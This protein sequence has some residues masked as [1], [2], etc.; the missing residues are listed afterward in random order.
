MASKIQE[1]DDELNPIIDSD[2][3]EQEAEQLRNR[4]NPSKKRGRNL[5][6]VFRKED[7]ENKKKLFGGSILIPVLVVIVILS[8]CIPIL[9]KVL[10]VYFPASDGRG[11]RK[12]KYRQNTQNQNQHQEKQYPKAEP[13]V[14]KK[15]YNLQSVSELK[16]KSVKD[17][18]TL[19][20]SQNIQYSDLSEKKDFI[21]R[22]RETIVK[23]DL[24]RM[25]KKELKSALVKNLGYKK[26]D[27]RKIDT[28]EELIDLYYNH[29]KK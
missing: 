3:S 23:R 14:V 16:K 24:R 28:H 26:E 13:D 11:S 4:K 17:L 27:L 19:L 9:D 21:N 25:T 10:S 7:E 20:W 6:D 1:V 8:A 18:K 22:F 15:N 12:G 2:E 29:E 5:D